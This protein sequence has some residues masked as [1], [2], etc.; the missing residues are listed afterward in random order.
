[1]PASVLD[2]VFQTILSRRG[3]DP[4]KSYTAALFSRG[5][6]HVARKVGEEAM[7]TVIAAVEEDHS[8]IVSESADLMFHLLVLLADHGLRPEDVFAELERREGTSGVAEK[9]SRPR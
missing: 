3:G 1:M 9:A 6:A 8:A 4:E 5:H 2:R 7:E